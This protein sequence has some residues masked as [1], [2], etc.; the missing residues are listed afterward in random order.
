MKLTAF[1]YGKTL[2]PERMAFQGGAD[3]KKLPIALLFFLLETDGK[4]LLVDVG[5][6]TMPGFVVTDFKSPVMM[7]EEYGVSRDEIDAILLSHTHHDH[8]DCLRHYPNA[9]V[10]VQENEADE[11]KEYI[12]FDNLIC[13]FKDTLKISENITMKHIGGHSPASSVVIIESPGKNFVLCG[14]EC[15]TR[16]N[17]AKRKPTGSSFC[18][19]KSIAFVEEYGKDCYNTVLFHDPDLVGKTG[20]VRLI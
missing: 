8:I 18:I 10:Y 9:T 11:A 4:K 2:L 15:Y 12:R 20:C 5:C 3:D 1:Q 19:K 14:D 16:E 13:T 6:D 17:L 7:L